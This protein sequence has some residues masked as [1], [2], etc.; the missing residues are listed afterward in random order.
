M[1]KPD[2]PRPTAT[3][4]RR[5][6][7]PAID[8][9]KLR[10]AVRRLGDGPVFYMLDGAIDLLPPAKLAKLVGGYLDVKLLRPDAPGKKD[11]LDAARA[12]VKASRAGKYYEG[13]SVNSKNFMD[14]S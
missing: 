6:A 3:S 7:A 1:S 9:D 11:L 13:F 14:R 2:Q 10:A 5:S 12:F 4:T 8:R